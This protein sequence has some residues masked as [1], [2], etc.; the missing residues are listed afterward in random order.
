MTQRS[1]LAFACLPC[2]T[3]LL[4]CAPEAPFLLGSS[5][6]TEGGEDSGDVPGL[7]CTEDASA[8]SELSAQPTSISTV[9][10]ATWSTR[11]DGATFVRFSDGVV[12]RESVARLDSEEALILGAG[13]L[14]PV[15]WQVWVDQPGGWVC[16]PEQR[17]D[18]GALDPRIPELRATLEE[19]ASLHGDD[20]VVP[21]LTETATFVTVVDAAG[22]VI[23][24]Q[25]SAQHAFRAQL[26]RDGGALLVGGVA[27]HK[28]EDAWISRVALDGSSLGRIAVRGGHTDFVELPDRGIAMLGWDIRDYIGGQ[29][30]LGD[31]IVEVD[32]DGKQRL[33]WNLFDHYQPDLRN[34]Y[35]SEYYPHDPTVEDWSHANGIHYDAQDDSFLV[36]V[37]YLGLIIKVDRRTGD[38]LWAVG[39]TDPSIPTP[40][41]LIDNP[42]SIEV[43][44]DGSYRVFNRTKGGC[45]NVVTF[46]VDAQAGVVTPLGRYEGPDCLQV[47]F[48][49]DVKAAEDGSTRISWSSA[50]RLETLNDEGSSVGQIN[51]GFGAVFGFVDPIPSLYSSP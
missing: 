10:K 38:Q 51:L 4:A 5:G 49:G 16:S 7:R 24:S 1:P 11:L 37:S 26:A 50:G 15:R 6:G 30:I 45:S 47:V 21:I 22:R 39:A 23:W 40:T 13:P 36:S 31:T 46:S 3:L 14:L 29:R 27:S 41:G 48:L 20:V 35:W 34:A 43:L 28:D 2:A 32:P 33:I 17:Y 25:V 8:F 42:H 19:G 44:E 18:N 12:E 9:R